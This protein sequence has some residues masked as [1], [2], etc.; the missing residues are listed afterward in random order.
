MIKCPECNGQVYGYT[1]VGLFNKEHL[2]TDVI[3]KV[4]NVW[5]YECYE[6][7]S[8]FAVEYK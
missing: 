1:N 6:C 2:L 5:L 8:K 3:I 4:G 7:K